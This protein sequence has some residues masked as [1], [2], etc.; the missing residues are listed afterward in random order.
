MAIYSI[1]QLVGIILGIAFGILGLKGAFA[2]VIFA[3]G[4]AAAGYA[5]SSGFHGVDEEVRSS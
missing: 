5:Y 3:A 4:N 2:L 1:R